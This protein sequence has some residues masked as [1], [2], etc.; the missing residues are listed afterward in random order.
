MS[1]VTNNI[2]K[3]RCLPTKML[4]SEQLVVLKM[5]KIETTV[6]HDIELSFWLSIM[7]IFTSTLYIYD[8]YI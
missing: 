8:E 4:T 2:K 1:L 3:N 7:Q 5:T 6:M